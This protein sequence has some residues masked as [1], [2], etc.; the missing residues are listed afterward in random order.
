MHK[1]CKAA[2]KF[3]RRALRPAER[4]TKSA[5]NFAGMN[6]ANTSCFIG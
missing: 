6:T 1:V 2:S 3:W 5:R 4:A